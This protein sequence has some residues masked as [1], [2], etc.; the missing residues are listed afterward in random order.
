MSNFFPPLFFL[1]NLH[2]LELCG[3]VTL[4]FHLKREVGK[5]AVWL[6]GEIPKAP[7]P[8]NGT[9]LI[10]SKVILPKKPSV[11]ATLLYPVPLVQQKCSS[12]TAQFETPLQS[13]KFKFEACYLITIIAVSH[14]GTQPSDLVYV[15]CHSFSAVF[16]PGCSAQSS[17]LQLVLISVTFHRGLGWRWVRSEWETWDSE[18]GLKMFRDQ[19][20]K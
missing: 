19:R 7:N 18:S 17:L 20:E 13:A 16:Q 11:C 3:Y 4:R 8:G 2:L 9:I 1:K 10:L 14:V 6:A 5:P 15:S 12:S